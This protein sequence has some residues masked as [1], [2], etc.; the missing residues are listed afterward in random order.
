M[1]TLRNLRDDRVTFGPFGA[2]VD[3]AGNQTDP[4]ARI[5]LGAKCDRGVPNAWPHEVKLTADQEKELRA[6]PQVRDLL[7][8]NHI[9]IR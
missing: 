1:K 5:R 4:G 8:R 6:L 9:E 2:K 7:E 3:E